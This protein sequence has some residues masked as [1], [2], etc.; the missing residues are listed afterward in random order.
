MKTIRKLLCFLMSM[1]LAGF[2]LTSIAAGPQ[3]TYSSKVVANNPSYSGTPKVL[4][5]PVPITFTV[6]NESPPS[7]ANSNIGSYTFTM[8]GMQIDGNQPVTCPLARCSVDPVANTVTVTNI[9][10]PIQG[11]GSFAVGFSVTSCGDGS[12]ANVQVY[13][14]S[15]LTGQTFKFVQDSSLPTTTITNVSCGDLLCGSFTVPGSSPSVAGTRGL[16][17][18]GGACTD[19][20]LPYFVTNTLAST[21][22]ALHFR[23]PTL[24]TETSP[25]PA[26]AF[27]YTIGAAISQMSW[28]NNTAGNPVFIPAPS[29][30]GAVLPF[31]YTTLAANV[32][33]NDKKILVVNANA[34]P[35][36]NFDIV[37][38][39]ERMTVTKVTT[40]NGTLT[41]TRHVGGTS[42]T[43]HVAGDD[44]M[45][46]PLPLL[47]GYSFTQ[48][49]TQAG[50]ANGNQAQM[51]VVTGDTT[52]T[53]VIDIGDGWHAP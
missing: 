26:A 44:V 37:V 21:T 41:V 28:L 24:V 43:A 48:A 15:Q 30:P 7:T 53:T 5:P 51:C 17:K 27:Q 31:S 8:V 52:S 39:T 33:Q 35:S 38:G 11:Q 3:K 23:W 10:P 1:T 13:T 45:S 50:Y 29:C 19:D 6:K 2:A 34:L 40:S 20:S 36:V 22:G 32:A 14:G 46:T 12:V 49:Q 4:V 47:T 18:D 25:D 9:S 42:A 16:D